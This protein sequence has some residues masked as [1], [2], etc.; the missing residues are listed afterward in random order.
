MEH[1]VRLDE[2]DVEECK[3]IASMPGRDKRDQWVENAYRKGFVDYNTFL[4]CVGEKAFSKT[5]FDGSIDKSISSLGDGGK[6][7]S[8]Y[9]FDIDVKCQATEAKWAI[10]KL[11]V[12]GGFYTIAVDK[13]GREKELKYDMVFFSVVNGLFYNNK[14]IRN[15]DIIKNT[16][17]NNHQNI[18]KIDIELVGYIWKKDILKNKNERIAPTLRRSKGSDKN[19]YM[20]REELKFP[21][22]ISH[23]NEILEWGVVFE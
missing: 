5:F 7:F 9:S 18:L 23:F 20:K 14:W 12:Y 19:Y 10:E 22:S 4:G 17:N 11:G 3:T 15:Y 1:V 16:L 13:Y 6:D 8:C 2:Q 21:S